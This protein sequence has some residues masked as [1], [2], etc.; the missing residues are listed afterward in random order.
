MGE[1]WCK[2][3]NINDRSI[4]YIEKVSLLLQVD[5]DGALL[6]YLLLECLQYSCLEV[7]G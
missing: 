4:I 1:P 7:A 5:R 3:G 6:S 2:C